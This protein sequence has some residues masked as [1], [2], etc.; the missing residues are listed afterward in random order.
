MPM[1]EVN[2]PSDRIRSCYIC[3]EN[4]SDDDGPLVRD[5][6]CR[7]EDAGFIHLSCLVA[8]AEN[9]SKNSLGNKNKFIEPWVKCR[10]CLQF[11]QNE[12]SVVMANK[13]VSFV[14]GHPHDLKFLVE[15]I[16]V[17]LFA[18]STIPILLPTQREEAKEI[19]GKILSLIDRMK[20]GSTRTPSMTCLQ[21]A[22][23]TSVTREATTVLPRRYLVIEASTYRTLGLIV[24]NEGTRESAGEAI[25]HYEKF[26]DLS[27]AI[28]DT[29]GVAIAEREISIAKS[30]HNLFVIDPVERLKKIQAVYDIHVETYGEESECAITSGVSLA[31]VLWDSKRWV[32]AKSLIA[33]LA[34]ISKRVLGPE[35]NTTK[36]VESKLHWMEKKKKENA[37]FVLYVLALLGAFV[38]GLLHSL[39]GL[40]I[41]FVLFTLGFIM[42]EWFFS[43][44]KSTKGMARGSTSA[45]AAD[46]ANV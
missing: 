7:G 10:S 36:L 29:Q 20:G 45:Q 40:M 13:F 1:S 17:K 33:K 12:L 44:K 21:M 42:L 3:W 25:A 43:L 5:C 30:K 16:N 38:V 8:S 2:A 41:L 4:E 35:H 11:Y 31:I 19:G 26:L 27:K 24:L 28:N 14:E 22:E 18:L 15:A 9:E 37:H 32:E 23:E 34:S 46:M 6:A 39:T